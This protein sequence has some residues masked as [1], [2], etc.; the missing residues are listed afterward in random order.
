MT[1]FYSVADNS[2]ISGL[3]RSHCA[4][5]ISEAAGSQHFVFSHVVLCCCSFLMS[6]H[7]SQLYLL[8]SKLGYPAIT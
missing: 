5:E 2:S 6:A 3:C 4:V 7:I 8:K 1:T